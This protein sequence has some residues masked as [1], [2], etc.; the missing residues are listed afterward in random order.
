MPEMSLTTYKKRGG[1]SDHGKEYE[2]LLCI[3]YALKFALS[4]E[5]SD[6]ELWTNN[7]FFGDFDDVALR[8]RFKDGVV[9]V[10]LLQSKH[11]EKP[12]TIT[13]DSMTSENGDFAFHKYKK[14]YEKT[15]HLSNFVYILFT[16][17]TSKFKDKTKVDNKHVLRHSPCVARNFLN[18]SKNSYVNSVYKVETEQNSD[19]FRTLYLY[20]NQQNVPNLH[21][22]IADLLQTHFQTDIKSTFVDFMRNWWS[23]NF[24]LSKSDIVA[25]LVELVL[26]PMIQTLTCDINNEK[27]KLLEAAILKFDLTLVEQNGGPIAQI[28]SRRTLDN[29]AM[30]TVS[31]TGQKYGLVTHRVSKLD[32]LSREQQSR[33]AWYMNLWPLVVKVDETKQNQINCALNLLKQKKKRIVLLGHSVDITGF[34][35]FRNLSDLLEGDSLRSAIMQTFTCSLQGKLDVTLNDLGSCLMSHFKVKQLVKM[36]TSANFNIGE[37][38]ETL[39]PTYIERTFPKI[40]LDYKVIDDIKEWNICL[41]CNNQKEQFRQKIK[42]RMVKITTTVTGFSDFPKHYVAATEGEFPKSVIKERYQYFKAGCH[43]RVIGQNVQWL[44]NRGNCRDFVKNIVKYVKTN[45]KEVCT[46]IQIEDNFHCDVKVLTSH[47][48]SGKTSLLKSVKNRALTNTFVMMFNLREHSG[49]FKET[50]TNWKKVWDYITDFYP[51]SRNYNEFETKLV[52]DFPKNQILILWDSFDELQFDSRQNFVKAMS[53]LRLLGISQWIT[54]KNHFRQSLEYEFETFALTMLPFHQTD[55][56][57]YLENRCGVTENLLEANFLSNCQILDNQEYLGVPL[58]LYIISDIFNKNPK[59]LQGVYSLADMFHAFIEGRFQHFLSKHPNYEDLTPIINDSREYRLGQY[60]IAAVKTH[61]PHVFDKL[62]LE[63]TTRFVEEIQNGDFLGLVKLDQNGGFIFEFQIL[64]EY[65][66]ALFLSENRQLGLEFIFAPKYKNIRFLFDLI[67][68]ENKP[69]LISLLYKKFDNFD[70]F[71]SKDKLGRNALHLICAYGERHPLLRTEDQKYAFSHG[72]SAREDAPIVKNLVKNLTLKCDIWE[73]DELFNWT[74]FDYA[75]RSLSLGLLEILSNLDNVLPTLSNF[76]DLPTVL[77]YAVKFDYQNLFKAAHKDITF[78]EDSSGVN[79]LHVATEFDREQFLTWFLTQKIYIEGINKQNSNHWAPI[80]IASFNG[81][82]TFLKLLQTKGATFP[83]RDPSLVSLATSHPHPHILDFLIECECSVNEFYH[84]NYFTRS[85]P[86][87]IT[88]GYVDIVKFLV[89]NGAKF[90][91]VGKNSMNALHMAL[92]VQKYDIAEIFLDAGIN[93]DETDDR[94][95]TSVHHAAQNNHN[96]VIEWLVARGAKID[97]FDSHHRNALHW[98]AHSGSLQAAEALIQAE[99]NIDV[100]DNE[101]FTPLHLAVLSGQLSIVKLL[102]DNKCD[103]KPLNKYKRTPLHLVAMNDLTDMVKI[104]LQTDPESVD[105]IESLY[106][107]TPLHYAAWNGHPD[108]VKT[109]LL[110]NASFDSRCNFGYTPLHLAVESENYDC[111]RLL[112]EAGARLDT[113]NCNGATPRDLAK[114]FNIFMLMMTFDTFPIHTATT[115][116]KY[117]SIPEIISLGREVNQVDNKGMTPLHLAV[118][119]YQPFKIVKTLLDNG[120][121]VNLKDKDGYTALHHLLQGLCPDRDTFDLLI[122]GRGEFEINSKTVKFLT[123]LHIAAQAGSFLLLPRDDTLEIFEYLTGVL[124]DKGANIEAKDDDDFTPLHYGAQSGNLTIVKL[125]TRDNLINQVNKYNRT[126]LHMAAVKGHHTIVKYLL[127]YGAQQVKDCDGDTPLDDALKIESI[128]TIKLLTSD[129][130]VTS[131]TGRN[132]LHMAAKQGLFDLVETFQRDNIATSEDCQGTTPAEEALYN[133]HFKVFD[134]MDLS[135][136]DVNKYS[137]RYKKYPLHVATTCRRKL[138]LVEK[139]IKLGAK[140]NVCDEDGNTPLHTCQNDEIL[141]LLVNS[142]KSGLNVQNLKGQTILHLL[143]KERKYK[144]LLSLVDQ[145]G[146]VNI[147]DNDNN[148]VFDLLF[149]KDYLDE[150]ILYKVNQFNWNK[151]NREGNTLLHLAI[152]SKMTEAVQWLLDKGVSTRIE[153]SQGDTLLVYAIIRSNREIVRLLLKHCDLSQEKYLFFNAVLYGWEFLPELLPHIKPSNFT[154]AEQT[155][156]LQSV[157]FV[158]HFQDLWNLLPDADVTKIATDRGDTPL[159][160]SV[161]R[162]DLTLTS[163]LLQKGLKPND[164]NRNGETPTQIAVDR[165][166]LTILH[167]LLDNDRNAVFRSDRNG[168]TLLHDAASKGNLEMVKFLL[169]R[170]FRSDVCNGRG[171]TASEVAKEQGHDEIYQF[172]KSL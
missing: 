20:T 47:T 127:D 102:L 160:L 118:N 45:P 77:Y 156:F 106:G 57:Y 93:I 94:E 155:S 84:H 92:E 142:D 171:K 7:E 131:H 121:D 49:F 139:F 140:T 41:S 101:G 67:M 109:L 167:V 40:I 42:K 146:D 126:P 31:M 164:A 117:E 144:L 169:K 133:H 108:C 116:G 161:S 26:S 88:H 12:K 69:E 124:I 54:S 60:K 10:Y 99:I 78:V 46:E 2:W 107:R 19:F 168:N 151:T 52:K 32:Q 154:P 24:T 120:A 8:V 143:V 152:S 37:S 136:F 68:A 135:N 166:H 138:T 141:T 137:R 62:N 48:G 44:S 87:A 149:D 172:L 129:L 36:A 29:Q 89:K 51:K 83:L 65:L 81:N 80:Q 22:T 159:H 58:Q 70:N 14:S 82:L 96:G 125:L 17:R 25:K 165:G 63:N 110:S 148:T 28:W 162:K 97:V 119:T 5:I 153:N 74:C 34:D 73:K 122:T 55:Q 123:P 18:I 4:S 105:C 16:N 76:N 112:L 170:G 27:T 79:L 33:I 3:Y 13:L 11:T 150:K 56:I 114:D 104:F 50:H 75:D 163:R 90:Y 115:K 39:P 134:I 100:F 66:A 71:E 23:G 85:L 72:D 15:L 147:I 6:F 61:L 111:C 86:M 35:I 59:L 158:D 38:L 30:K 53:E 132:V 157:C 145:G 64:G 43:F 128:E 98:A 113:P 91:N 130:T 9:K 21:K 1:T 95:Q 103:P